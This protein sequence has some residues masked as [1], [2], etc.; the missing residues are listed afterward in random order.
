VFLSPSPLAEAAL[1]R[2]AERK[3]SAA[4]GRSTGMAGR[5]RSAMRLPGG[6]TELG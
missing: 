3:V 4:A 6:W 5:S 1:A 2:F